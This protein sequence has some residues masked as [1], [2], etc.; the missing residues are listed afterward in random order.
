[1]VKELT[2]MTWTELCEVHDKLCE[3]LGLPKTDDPVED[4]IRQYPSLGDRILKESKAT[5]DY[6]TADDS[7]SQWCEA[8][9]QLRDFLS[10]YDLGD[11]DSDDDEDED[12]EDDDSE[13]EDDSTETKPGSSPATKPKIEGDPCTAFRRTMDSASHGRPDRDAYG[14]RT[15]RSVESD[16]DA[17]RKSRKE[18]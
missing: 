16:R 1:L 11:D 2:E 15:T 13:D 3:E 5:S 9:P 7:L 18:A 6:L 17:F 12:S 4:W 14:R 8:V 10:E